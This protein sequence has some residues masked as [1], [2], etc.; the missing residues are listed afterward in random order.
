MSTISIL[1]VKELIWTFVLPSICLIGL[2]TNSIN[3]F[4]FS[5]R[6]QMGLRNRMHQYFQI[7]SIS[8]FFY[9]LICLVYYLLKSRVLSAYHFSY[10]FV[11]YEKYFFLYLAS[12]L[13]CFML[14]LRLYISIRRLLITLNT[15]AY[16]QTIC[17][18]KIIV[19][20]LITS[21]FLNFPMISHV[22]IEV[23]QFSNISEFVSKN[24]SSVGYELNFK[25]HIRNKFLKLVS[26]ALFSFRGFVA[27][28]VL[29]C[30]NLAI[31]HNMRKAFN[32]HKAKQGELVS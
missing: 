2:V 22:V 25:R 17:L 12:V 27:P 10:F 15:G 26:F 14:L 16:L 5:E 13:A 3:F 24:Q 9:L 18:R 21:F 32:R 11:I 28:F 1:V 23:K 30:V 4:I 31:V 20:F 29:L 19:V 7:D 6:K 8:E